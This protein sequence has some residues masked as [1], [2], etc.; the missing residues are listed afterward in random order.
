MAA[1]ITNFA[2]LRFFGIALLVMGCW[3][4]HLLRLLN[5][6]SEIDLVHIGLAI[7]GTLALGALVLSKARAIRRSALGEAQPSLTSVHKTLNILFLVAL[8]TIVLGDVIA[9]SD[10]ASK[11]SQMPLGTIS[12]QALVVKD[13]TIARIGSFVVLAIYLAIGLR[14][15]PS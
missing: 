4:F 5:E 15:R 2:F 11:L 3:N 14:S 8:P 9:I 6:W 7:G 1:T 12:E 10:Y 13:T